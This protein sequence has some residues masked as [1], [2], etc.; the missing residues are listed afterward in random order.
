MAGSRLVCALSW[1]ER[2]SYVVDQLAL[3][4]RKGIH[5]AD[6]LRSSDLVQETCVKV[7]VLFVD[8]FSPIFCNMKLSCRISP[9]SGKS[10]DRCASCPFCSLPGCGYDDDAESDCFNRAIGAMF[11][12]GFDGT[13]VTPQIRSLIEDHHLGSILLTT[14]NLKCK[15]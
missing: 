5:L 4:T 10:A 9:P 3:D 13:E 8:C 12:M 1:P 15:Y 6:L 7:S 11:F 2:V 14:K